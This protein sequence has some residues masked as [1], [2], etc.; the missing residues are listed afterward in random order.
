M[1]LPVSDYITVRSDEG[2]PLFSLFLPF[3]SPAKTFPITSLI[4]LTAGRFGTI[5]SFP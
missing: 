3:I 5:E 1:V 4:L 2:I